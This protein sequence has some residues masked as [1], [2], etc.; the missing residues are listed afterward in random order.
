MWSNVMVLLQIFGKY[1]C[2]K[3][4]RI[5]TIPNKSE[6]AKKNNKISIKFSDKIKVEFKRILKLDMITRSRS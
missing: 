3:T 2:L 5:A 1:V 6:H 4:L